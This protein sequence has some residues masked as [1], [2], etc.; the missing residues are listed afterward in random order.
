M[1]YVKAAFRGM[2]WVLWRFLIVLDWL[3]SGLSTMRRPL[4]WDDANARYGLDQRTSYGETIGRYG[5]RPGERR[6]PE[7]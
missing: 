1:R 2:K 6:P 4:S 3:F 7:D 5:P